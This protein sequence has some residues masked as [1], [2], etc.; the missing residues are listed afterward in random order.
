[1]NGFLLVGLNHKTAS[2]E[3]RDRCSVSDAAEALAELK[4][5][6]SE[7]AVVNT[8]NRLEIY[9]H[10]APGGP[11]PFWAWIG[12]RAGI[13]AAALRA[14]GY[15][16][17]GRNAC[18]HLFF[19]A[20]S[21]D[22]LVVGETQIRRQIRNAYQAAT[23]C[24]AVGSMLHGLFQTALRV[25]KEIADRT[26]LGRGNV[27]VAG[28]AADLAERVFEDLGKASVL[29]V[30]AG[31]T[32]ELILTHLAGR[33]VGRVRVLNRTL[34]H[35]RE[36]ADR[37]GAEAG[38]L[39]GMALA[40][41]EADVVIAAAPGAPPLVTAEAVRG[42]LRRRRGRPM[43]AVDIAVPRAVDPAVD[44]L[45][46]VYRYDMDALVAVTQDALRHR[47][48]EFLQCC[49]MVDAATLHL[50][51][52]THGREVGSVIRELERLFDSIAEQELGALER[53]LPE[54]DD[55]GRHHVRKAVHRIV[56][57]LLHMPV[58]AIRTGGPEESEVIRKTFVAPEKRES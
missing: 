21:L 23:E 57:K 41:A 19:V 56:R 58:R 30:G 32:A 37:F 31:D 40:L 20:S 44:D 53:R 47:R 46:N 55:Q 42:A 27:S 9:A 12:R 33:G 52:E 10:D 35:A 22:S 28:A 39:D 13:D 16:R 7:V 48:K 14:K 36:L 5:L 54:L 49:T 43:L 2:A 1:M 18:K 29:V 45:D 3:L 24:G 51:E 15:V 38:G 50:A 26:G 11:D 6:A 34:E 4:P 8:C 17:T 25:S